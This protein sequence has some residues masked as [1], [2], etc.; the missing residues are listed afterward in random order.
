MPSARTSLRA[1]TIASREN[2]WLKRFRAALRSPDPVSAEWIGVE[3][4]RLVEDAMASNLPLAAVIVSD[5]GERHLDHLLPLIQSRAG[6]RVRLLRT[7]DRLFAGIADTQ[8]PQGVAALLRPPAWQFDN[9]LRGSDS[10]IV[11]LVGVQDPGNVGTILRT[12]E[13]F[14]ASGAIATGASAHPLLPKA[15]RASAG[16][17]LRLPCIAGQAPAVALVQLRVS[18]LALVASSA[19]ARPASLPSELN[20]TQPLAL[21]VGNEGAGLPA[22]IERSADVRVRIPLAESVDSLNAAVAAAVLL[23][24]AARQRRQATIA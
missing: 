6:E 9:L 12:A 8:S 4:A 7:S 17:A 18:G 13:A 22:D 23:Y 1:E 20:F 21:L 3:G 15:I 2:A 24:E 16:S 5:S 19:A 11:V 14:G 10:L